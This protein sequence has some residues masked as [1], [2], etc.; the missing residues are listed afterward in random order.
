M[1]FASDNISRAALVV[2]FASAA[3][4]AG[5][6]AFQIWGELPPCPMCL[7]QR[8]AYY[9]A[10]P[11]CL[12]VLVL[13]RSGTAPGVPRWGLA[14][15]GLVVFAGCILA[16]YHAGVEW[17]W[18]E[19]PTTCTGTGN[20]SAENSLLPDLGKPAVVPCDEAA[21]RLF[22]ISLAGYNFLIALALTAICAWAVRTPGR[23]AGA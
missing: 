1:T 13:R 23:A 7:Q 22:G 9:A 18:W 2:L 20:F 16:G 11:L 17:K 6:W 19:G 5:A 3:L 15:C 10:I 21:W 4:L 8:W 14:L 12:L